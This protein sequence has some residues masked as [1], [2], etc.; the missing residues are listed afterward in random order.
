MQNNGPTAQGVHQFTFFP[1]TNSTI[2]RQLLLNLIHSLHPNASFD[3]DD[4][5]E[6]DDEDWV[7]RGNFNESEDESISGTQYDDQDDE[8]QIWIDL[9]RSGRVQARDEASAQP[10]IN[11]VD[12]D[13][14]DDDDCDRLYDEINRLDG[15]SN[16]NIGRNNNA[17]RLEGIVSSSIRQRMRPV[18]DLTLDEDDDLIRTFTTSSNRSNNSSSVPNSFADTGVLLQDA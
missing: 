18:V 15:T 6:E 8:E 3:D 1:V 17:R 4:E 11:L 16:N 10:L 14:D 12:D 7:P 9:N 2:G 13:D 5:E